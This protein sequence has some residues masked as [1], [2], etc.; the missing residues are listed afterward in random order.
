MFLV[1]LK[2]TREMHHQREFVLKVTSSGTEMLL[3]LTAEKDL[4]N[5]IVSLGGDLDSAS[6]SWSQK[7]DA[8]SPSP[9]RSSKSKKSRSLFSKKNKK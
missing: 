5:W 4:T 8:A 1:D 6:V 3:E 2:V 7:T 9:S